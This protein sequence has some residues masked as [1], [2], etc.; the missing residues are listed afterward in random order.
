MRVEAVG[1]VEPL[2]AAD[3]GAPD[4]ATRDPIVLKFGSSVLRDASD[5]K[6]VVSEIYRYVRLGRKVVAVV[7]A[8]DGETDKLY[9]EAAA[10]GASSQ[11][12]HA[13]R[14]IALGEDRSA[15]LLAI[16]C[17]VVGL[18]ARIAGARQLSLHA[19]GPVDDA[20]PESIN[21][22]ALQEA[23]STHDVVIVPGF[24]A[25]GASGEPVLLGRGGSDLTAV[26]VARALVLDEVTLVKDVDGVY[27]RDPAVAGTAA[28]RFHILD[29]STAREVAGKLLQPKSIDYAAACEVA[30]NVRKLGAD[31]GTR[32]AAQSDKPVPAINPEPVRV[33]VAG[34]GVIG[35]GAATRILADGV[36]LSFSCALVRD[37]A[38]PRENVFSGQ[39][40]FGA[41]NDFIGAK[42]DIVVDALPS[43][44]AG[45]ALIETALTRGVSVVSANKQ[46]LAGSLAEFHEIAAANGASLFYSAAV[47]GGAPM[48]ETIRCARQTGS[49]QSVTAILNG[50]VNFILSE[51]RNGQSFENAIE[52]AQAAG[53]AEPDPSADL[54]GEDA[55]AKISILCFEAFGVEP[56]PEMI[57]IEPL[58]QE[59]AEQIAQG[60]SAWKQLANICQA[61]DGKIAASLKYEPVGDDTLFSETPGES[62]ALRVI[63]HGGRQFECR[64]KGAGRRPTV[65]SL[66]A[67]IGDHRRSVQITND[68]D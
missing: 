47:G 44:S 65:E 4:P 14:L 34:L 38:K 1:A 32:V 62:N 40:L 46:A 3:F 41:L 19:G 28:R 63:V 16:A 45:K 20:H 24:V 67:D 21:R 5:L 53:F 30:I 35:A 18:D 68:F 36:D 58:T 66:L 10:L 57:A 12:R 37:A 42:P 52:Q 8:F 43:R 7:S 48:V 59:L 6:D 49:V 27:D 33:G 25:L 9:A 13:P 50:T 17:D 29:W 15:A 51:M 39:R 31:E 11:S 64:G 54:S 22:E 2:S 61:P 55:R 26:C 23:L 56:D 60:G